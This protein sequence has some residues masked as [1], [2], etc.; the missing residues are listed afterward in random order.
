MDTGK[1]PRRTTEVDQESD[2][3]PSVELGPDI[4]TKIGAQL[5]RVYDEIVNQG[6]PE[7]FVEILRRLDCPDGGST[8]ESR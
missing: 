6:L 1:L 7:R 5:R 2:S 4:T 8:T 3:N